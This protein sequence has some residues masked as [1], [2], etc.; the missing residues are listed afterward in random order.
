MNGESKGK[1]YKL[2]GSKISIGRGTNADIILPDNNTS[3]IHA[4][5][6]I[7]EG[8]P[9]IRDNQSANGILV[10]KKSVEHAELKSRDKI[11]IGDTYLEFLIVEQN[12]TLGEKSITIK[13]MIPEDTFPLHQ[14]FQSFLQKL[15]APFMNFEP[16]TKKRKIIIGILFAFALSMYFL[17]K[18]NAEEELQSDTKAL[19]EKQEEGLAIP[20]EKDSIDLRHEFKNEEERKKHLSELYSEARVF[21]DVGKYYEALNLIHEILLCDPTYTVALIKRN[22]WT[23]ERDS[24][25]EKLLQ[26]GV[27]AYTNKYYDLA[28]SYFQKVLDFVRTREHDLYKKAEKG[29]SQVEKARLQHSESKQ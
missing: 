24:I 27:R 18:N 9:V 28:M 5:F 7:T 26:E 3:R 12:T 19:Q 15:K 16:A 13:E 8:R 1:L 11:L 21:H 4:Y 14:K 29:M 23:A 10:N 17:Q 2:V 6:E 20:E 22:T 25:A